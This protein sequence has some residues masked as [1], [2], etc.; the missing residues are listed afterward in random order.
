MWIQRVLLL[1]WIYGFFIEFYRSKKRKMEIF[2]QIQI[3]FAIY[4]I[5][6]HQPCLFN[7]RNRFAI[8]IFICGIVFTCAY[9]LFEVDAFQDYADSISTAAAPI[10]TF[11]IFVIIAWK[12]RE[13]FNFVQETETL[14]VDRESD[15]G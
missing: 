8:L 11:M 13:F 5:G 7:W 3:D 9:I 6:L 1:N 2:R 10:A 12:M 14:I 15:V 4:G